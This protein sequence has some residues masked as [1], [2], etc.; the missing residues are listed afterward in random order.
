ML[1]YGNIKYGVLVYKVIDSY[2]CEQ[3]LAKHRSQYAIFLYANILP[4][5]PS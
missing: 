4:C 5:N 1:I 2:S 3:H